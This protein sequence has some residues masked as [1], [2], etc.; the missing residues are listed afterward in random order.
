MGTHFRAITWAT[1]ETQSYTSW[2][3][4]QLSTQKGNAR[5]LKE[6]EQENTTLEIR[7]NPEE[8]A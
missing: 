5:E 2:G 4:A 3:T 8:R 6:G 1:M 7:D